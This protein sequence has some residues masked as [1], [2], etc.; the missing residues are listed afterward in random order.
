[1]AIYSKSQN[2]FELTGAFGTISAISIAVTNNVKVGTFD[3]ASGDASLI[4]T[5]GTNLSDAYLGSTGSVVITALT[6]TTVTGTFY[7]TTI[8]LS[9]V[10]GAV[11]SGAF[12][13][14]LITQ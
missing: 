13:A 8:N 4:Y 10:T 2:V 3:I 5:T 1:V 7:A 14:K 11:T 9:N 6:S 12:N